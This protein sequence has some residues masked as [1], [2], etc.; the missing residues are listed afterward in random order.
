[1]S[2][3]SATRILLVE[4]T[5]SLALAFSAHLENAGYLVDTAHLGAQARSFLRDHNYGLI[6]LDLQLPDLDGLALLEEVRALEAETLVIVVTADASAERV[7]NAMRMG[8]HDYLVK[9]V[10][11][12]R[13]VLTVR[14]ALQLVEL[15]QQ[16]ES[17]DKRA[18]FL[19]FIGASKPMQAVYNAIE[20]V[21]QSKATVFITGESGTG[22]EVC[23]EALHRSGPRNGK[24]FV[25]I[26]CGAIPSELIESEIF[27]HVKGAFTGAIS[28]RDGAATMA[29]GGTL[30]LDEICEMEVSLQ[31]KLLRFLQTNLIQRVGGQKPEEVDLRVVCATNRNPLDEVRAGRFREDLYYR[32]N[33]IPLSLPPLREREKDAILIAR[34]FLE[35]FSEEE[36]KHF[37]DFSL[38]AEKKLL[39]Y[40]WP[41]NV[42][43][44]QNV[45]RRIVVMND[46]VSV[47]PDML[48][49][50]LVVP[51][52]VA[53]SGGQSPQS[54]PDLVEDELQGKILD[55]DSTWVASDMTLAE[56]E[57]HVIESRLALHQGNVIEAAATLGVS[58]S[59]IYRKKVAW[60]SHGKDR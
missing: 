25:A 47:G 23:A 2:A 33:V 58:P 27:G 51:Q 39:E 44:L 15:R 16:I 59:T 10:T 34:D 49:D 43:E 26:N 50:T 54:R 45:I 20:N 24:P 19:G 48:P 22:K 52:P 40:P 55:S 4:D 1:M 3:E 21:S 12:D 56:I 35:R 30:F 60:E 29:D 31:T 11:P 17:G 42:R 57:R 6:L 37:H 41:G 5:V 38:E 46:A 28:N 32:L 36:G 7:V 18:R 13:M 9:P 8:A 14:N 53:T